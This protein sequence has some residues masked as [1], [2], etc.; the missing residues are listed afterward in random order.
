MFADISFFNSLSSGCNACFVGNSEL[1][2]FIKEYAEKSTGAMLCE[3]WLESI[4][5]RSDV[6][7]DLTARLADAS[8]DYDKEK[9]AA[10]TK[11]KEQLLDSGG[12]MGLDEEDKAYIGSLDPNIAQAIGELL[13]QAGR[14]IEAQ[15]ES[16]LQQGVDLQEA[17]GDQGIVSPNIGAMPAPS[18]PTPQPQQAQMPAQ[19]VPNDISDVEY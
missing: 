18:Q 15:V 13:A 17:L 19:A 10:G 3:Q 9:A 16:Q 14:D 1:L 6:T 7:A 5:D 12:K 2:S 11:L 4:R 8:H